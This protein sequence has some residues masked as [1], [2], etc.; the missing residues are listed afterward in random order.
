MKDKL[1]NFNNPIILLG[2]GIPPKNPAILK[3]F[4]MANSIICL[5]G[6]AD[7]LIRIGLRPDII[8]GDLDSLAKDQVE[9]PCELVLLDDQSKNDLEKCLSWCCAIGIT[10]L[11]LIGFTGG[12][13]DHTMSNLWVILSYAHKIKLVIYTDYSTIYCVKNKSSFKTLPGQIVSIIAPDKDIKITTT[14]LEYQINN[15]NL[16][17]PSNGISN[18]ANN[19]TCT[20]QSTDWVWVFL[21]HTK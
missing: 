13:D 8:L 4:K 17:S 11:S 7:K 15:S 9:Y 3:K 12:R 18:V 19:K 6:A 20:I 1:H 10:E 5:D 16:I 21:N 2:N 14:G